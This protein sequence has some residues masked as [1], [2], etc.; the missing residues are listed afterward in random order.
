MFTIKTNTIYLYLYI[1]VSIP[2]LPGH[3]F[4]NADFTEILL[5]FCVIKTN[6]PNPTAKQQLE[7]SKEADGKSVSEQYNDAGQQPPRLSNFF[8]IYTFR[9]LL[10]Y[11]T[12]CLP[13]QSH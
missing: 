6:C 9:L 13:V 1:K 3:V 7:T 12:S 11:G 10:H 8:P 2:E 5:C 4:I